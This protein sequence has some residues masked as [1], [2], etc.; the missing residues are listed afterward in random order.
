M[1]LTG[2]TDKNCR[3]DFSRD[4]QRLRRPMV[5]TEVA[6]TGTYVVQ[7][8]RIIGITLFTPIQRGRTL[9]IKRR[10]AAYWS[11]GPFSLPRGC[12]SHMYNKIPDSMRL[13]RL[14]GML[15]IK[16]AAAGW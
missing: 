2:E 12:I 14:M 1:N 9:T 7:A 16:M 11:S 6:P 13:L 8:I 3:S 15:Q 10:K 4:S 5:A